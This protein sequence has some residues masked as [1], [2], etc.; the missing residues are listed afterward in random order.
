MP[1]YT[2]HRNPM[3]VSGTVFTK[4]SHSIGSVRA[5][6]SGPL[7]RVPFQRLVMAFLLFICVPD[8]GL[9]DMD[10]ACDQAALLAAGETSVPLNV[11]RA[12]TRNETGRKRNGATEPWPWTVNM[13]GEGFW[14]DTEDQARAFVFE[15][16]KTGARSFDVGCFQINYKWH[17]SAFNS[18]EE[19]FEPKKNAIYAARFLES[20]FR[21]TGNWLDAV[22]AYHSR[23]PKYAERYKRKYQTILASLDPPMHTRTSQLKRRETPSRVNSYPLLSSRSAKTV[24]GSLVPLG[25]GSG[26]ATSL[27]FPEG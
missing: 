1:R 24:M 26:S 15:R 9:A 11:L 21:E 12:V 17:G 18:I 20:L 19:M 14:F 27:I 2:L 4:A 25:T 7:V 5:K 23:T 16:F 13:E 22:G 3:K 8:E 10:T 6:G